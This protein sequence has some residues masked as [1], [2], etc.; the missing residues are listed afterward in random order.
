VE[1]KA[2]S[3][4]YRKSD[5]TIRIDLNA[6]NGRGLTLNALSH[7]LTH[8]VQQWSPEKY[9][10]LA[11]FLIKTYEKTDMSMHDR[12]LREQA[13]LKRVRKEDVSYNEAYDEVVANAM[14]KMFDDGHL[15]EKLKELASVDKSLVEKILEGIK[16]FFNKFLAVYEKQ[17]ALFHDTADIMVMKK[18]FEK[19]QNIFAEALVDASQNKQAYMIALESNTFTESELQTLSEAGFGFDENTKSMYSSHFSTAYQDEIQVGKKTFNTEAIVQLVAKGTGRSIKDARKWVKSEMTIANMVLANPE[20][21]DFEADNRYEAIKKNSDYPQGTVDLSNLCPKREEFTAMFDMLQKKYPNKLF[22]AQDVADMRKILSDNDITVACG[23]CFV[24]DRRQLDGPVAQDFIDSLAIYR[25]GGKI[26]PDGKP[27]NANQ[28]KAFKLIEGDTYTP[29]IYELIS[30]KGRNSLKAK[31]PKMEEAWV[32][33]NNARGMQ[34]VRLLL[35]DAEYKRQILKY[36]PAV[37]KRKN[38]L[39][40]LRIYSLQ[41]RQQYTNYDAMITLTPSGSFTSSS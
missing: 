12:V 11:D 23:A 14:G 27:F 37:V 19:L 13:R 4:V 17:S 15:L 8:F 25:E 18:E 31:N 33:F 10:V 22:T 24:E 28:L 21:L 5:G 9:E 16:E 35:N 2:Y 41:S 40:G 20:F 30:L 29:S 32:K 26:R 39:G 7:E 3:G 1:Q 38:D 34:S 36:T 6:Y